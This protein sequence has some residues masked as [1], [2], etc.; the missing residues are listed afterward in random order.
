MIRV[1][2]TEDSVAIRDSFASLLDPASGFRLVG[3]ANDGL[4]RVEK[5]RILPP[6]LCRAPQCLDSPQT[7]Y[8]RR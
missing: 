1:L 5:A 7:R 3:L 6:L 2:I 8:H 4:E